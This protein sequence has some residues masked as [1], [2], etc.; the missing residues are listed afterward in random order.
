VFFSSHN[1][2]LVAK[3]CDRAAIIHDGKLHDIIDLTVEGN[4][5]TLEEDFLAI[6]REEE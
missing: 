4:K 6:T 3:L 1:L 2:D 5:E